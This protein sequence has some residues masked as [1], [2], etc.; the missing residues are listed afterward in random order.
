MTAKKMLAN[1]VAAM[2]PSSPTD[3]RARP[4]VEY[5]RAANMACNAHMT[6]CKPLA[7][8][9][10]VDLVQKVRT[11]HPANVCGCSALACLVKNTLSFGVFVLMSQNS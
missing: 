11:S 1:A 6:C 3:V 4:A 8:G 2:T 9:P 7:C 5:S 10:G